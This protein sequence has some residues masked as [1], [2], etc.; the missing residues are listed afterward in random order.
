MKENSAFRVRQQPRLEWGAAGPLLAEASRC[1]GDPLPLLPILRAAPAPAPVPGSG[2]TLALWEFLAALAAEDLTAARAVEPHLDAAA[3]LA[4]ARVESPAGTTW[5]VFA[6][7]SSGTRLEAKPNNDGGA[8]LL[9]GTKPWCSLAAQLD[10][11]VVTAHVEGGRRAFAVDLTQPA[12]TV[13]PAEW[14]SRGLAAVPSGPVSF[15]QA[16]GTPVGGTDWYLHRPGFAWG[17]IG[18]A[19]CWFGGA[20]GLF[21]TL[22]AAATSRPPDQLA[23]A[24]LGEA[25]R[26]LAAGADVLAA[27]AGAVDDG[28][29]GAVQAHRVRGQIAAVCSRMLEICGHALGPAPMVWDEQHARR[30]ADLSVYIRQHHAVRDDAALGTI[31]MEQGESEW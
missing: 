13:E 11:A 27:A 1:A 25:D 16:A 31:M 14:I 23:L 24:W 12:V 2:N 9:S 6:A 22:R 30:M 5:G 18:V 8:W 7:E 26:L 15:Q 19:A 21:R 10:R 4:Q 28:A 20:V 3:I 17:G 29:A